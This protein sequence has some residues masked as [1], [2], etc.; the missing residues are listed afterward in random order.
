MCV[1]SAGL[2]LG[3][4]RA[5]CGSAGSSRLSPERS[6]PPSGMIRTGQIKRHTFSLTGTDLGRKPL[7]KAGHRSAARGR[8]TLSTFGARRAQRGRQD[9]QESRGRDRS[10]I[11]SVDGQLHMSLAVH[12]TACRIGD[13]RRTWLTDPDSD[14]HR[15]LGRGNGAEQRDSRAGSDVDFDNQQSSQRFS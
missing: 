8:R 7:R 1:V 13:L 14:L 15:T 11:R 5:T 3:T 4:A 10:S 9:G 6:K 2:T 12:H